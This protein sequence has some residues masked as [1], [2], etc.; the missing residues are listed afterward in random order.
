MNNTQNIV[1]IIP[2]QVYSI[3]EVHNNHW[4]RVGKAGIYKLIK[5][6]V[7]EAQNESTGISDRRIGITGQA[8]L[9]F[10]EKNKVKF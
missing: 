8:I 3:S 10:R 6:G 9:N 4:F 5:A 2:N 1:E 7:L